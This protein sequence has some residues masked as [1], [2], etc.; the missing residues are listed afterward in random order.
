MSERIMLKGRKAEKEKRLKE[1]DV[2]AN[3]YIRI[4]REI[5]DPYGGSFIDFE[6]DRA[7]AAMDDFHAIWR[8]ARQLKDE[9]RRI[10]AELNG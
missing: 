1:I 9:I 8:E 2:R 7:V 5:I 3:S 6:M 10:E 4:I